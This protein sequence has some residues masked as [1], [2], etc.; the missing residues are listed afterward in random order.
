EQKDV[1][2]LASGEKVTVPFDTLVMFSTNFHPKELFDGAALR[3]IQYKIKINSPSRDEL[4]Q[5][6]LMVSKAKGVDFPEEVLIRLF[7]QRY[8]EIDNKYANFHAVFFMNQIQAM[9]KY[10]P[11]AKVDE[12]MI[13]AA[14]ENLFVEDT[15]D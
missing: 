1:L 7:T 6:F 8:P 2:T 14:W 5:I 13:D 15:L 4:L 10:R 11:D 12:E 3:R 9:L